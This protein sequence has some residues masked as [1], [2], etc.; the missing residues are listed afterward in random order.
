MGIAVMSREVAP[1]GPEQLS[2]ETVR[3]LIKSHFGRIVVGAIVV[4]I[5]YVAMLIVLPY[6]RE[7]RIIREIKSLGGQVLTEFRGPEWI[8]PTLRDRLPIYDRV[9]SL[10][11]SHKKISLDLVTELCSFRHLARLD[12]DNS[13]LNDAG[14]ERLSALNNLLVLVLNRTSVTDVGLKH[15]QRL[16]HL[17]W[18]YLYGTSVTDL[19]L[20]CFS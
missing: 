20:S 19:G 18:V 17:R 13:E 6:Q 15:L 1:S 9:I 12:A 14:L 5:V 11:L 10:N 4:A 8:P 2:H 7:Q 16:K 3:Q